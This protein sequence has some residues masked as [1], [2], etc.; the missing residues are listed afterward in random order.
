MI[1]SSKPLLPRIIA[2]QVTEEHISEGKHCS[3]LHCPI[4]LSVREKM[5]D[6]RQIKFQ[7]VTGW[8]INIV[9]SFNVNLSQSTGSVEMQT[10]IRIELPYEAKKFIRDFDL[11]RP[12]FPFSF[13]IE[14]PPIMG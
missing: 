3:H 13:N 5:G 11:N 1:A 7:S 10:I 8:S 14:L 2:V 9:F 12:V 6:N 4:A